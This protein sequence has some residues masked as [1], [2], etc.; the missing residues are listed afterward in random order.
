MIL[1]PGHAKRVSWV[2]HAGGMPQGNVLMQAV[3]AIMNFR[4]RGT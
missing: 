1:N 4:G 2:R 3:L